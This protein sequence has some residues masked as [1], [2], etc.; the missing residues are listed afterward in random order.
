MKKRITDILFITVFLTG[1]AAMSCQAMPCQNAKHATVKPSQQ[2][3]TNQDTGIDPTRSPQ[4]LYAF[5]AARNCLATAEYDKG[6]ALLLFCKTIAPHDAATLQSLGYMWQALQRADYAEYYY[7]SAFEQD[8]KSYWTNYAAMLYNREDYKEAARVLEEAVRQNPHDTEPLEAL[9]TVYDAMNQTKK[10]LQVQDRIEAIEGVTPFNTMTRY[11]LYAKSGDTKKAIQAIDRYLQDNPDDLR[12]RV[13]KGDIYL[14]TGK[15]KEALAIYFHEL[16]EHPDNPYALFSLSD[17]CLVNGDHARAAGYLRRAIMSDELEL[18]EKLQH[19]QRNKALLKEADMEEEMLKS[20]IDDFPLEDAGYQALTEYYIGKGDYTAGR[21]VLRTLLDIHPNDP[22][23][24]KQAIHILVEDTTATNEDF[25]EAIKHGYTLQPTD[26][27]WRYWKCR[28]LMVGNQP[29]S[30]VTLAE[31]S[32]FLD[33]DKRYK[34]QICVM[35]GDIYMFQENI[36][37]AYRAYEAA[38]AIDPQ[39]I[40]VLNNYAYTLATHEGDLKKAERMSQK[41]I[42]QEPYNATYL[43]TYAWILWLQGQSSLARFYIQK[44]KDNMQEQET[45]EIEEHYRIIKSE[46]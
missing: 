13:F 5:Y 43:D 15:E 42:E 17:Y 35:L 39:N 11:R 21:N 2:K 30:L 26:M 16:A 19:Y 44:A 7:R 4:F 33:G 27:E 41:T 34:L 45:E 8:S 20:L 46:E 14:Q 3:E 24:W 1:V 38:L 6:M 37:G 25:E 28:L 32:M 36:E 22:A 18:Q 23:L 29:D 9:S 10:A 40:Y 12:F 31:E